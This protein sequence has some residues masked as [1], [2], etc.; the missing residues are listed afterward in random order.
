MGKSKYIILPNTHRL[1][2]RGI[3]LS[4][5]SRSY[6]PLTHKQDFSE[7]GQAVYEYKYYRDLP[8]ARR[9]ELVRICS[10][11]ITKTLKLE[12]ESER[13]NFNS[14]IGVMPNRA[15]GYSLPLDLALQLSIK[16]E[17]LRDDSNCISKTKELPS[18][19]SLEDYKLRQEALKDAYSVDPEYDFE[20]IKGFLIIDDVFESGSTLR[21]V[22]R[23][24]EKAVPEI[25]RYVLSLTHLRKV[26]DLP[27]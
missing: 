20:G 17:W 2:E 10:S 8:L 15:S 14:C 24:L 19:K 25:P 13:L 9:Q 6:D 1:W 5:Y 12:E 11:A 22:C 3:S 7:L 23:T 4:L 16:F 26:W 18:M 21:E 27:R